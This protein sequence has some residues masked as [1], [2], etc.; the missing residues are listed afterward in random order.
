QSSSCSNSYNVAF[1]SS[2]NTSSINETV[3]A[4]H[5]IH[6][7]GLKETP[8]ASSYADDIDTDDLKEMDLKWQVAMITMRVKKIMKRTGRNLNFNGK[9]PGNRS[10]DNERRVISVETPASALVVQDGLGGYDWSYQAEERP[11][12]FALMAHSS[13]SANSSR[14]EFWATAKVN[15]VND[16]DQIQA[17]VDKTKVIIT[18]DSIRSDLRLDD[19]EGTACLL[20]QE[21]FEGLACM[22]RIEAGFSGII[23]PLFDTMMVQAL[24]DI[25]DIPVETH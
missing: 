16:K 6:A 2:K 21:I 9:E 24:A 17:L 15:K 18:E 1:V 5:D 19:A 4:A 13:D 7:A 14:F 23:T 20:N 25:G 8:S 22:G 10:A 3:T 11:T 12:D